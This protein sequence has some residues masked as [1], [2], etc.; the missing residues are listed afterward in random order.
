[1]SSSFRPNWGGFLAEDDNEY[2]QSD[3]P[4]PE[5]ELQEREIPEQEIPEQEIQ[6]QEDF[7]ERKGG[8]N[9]SDRNDL[10]RNDLDRNDLDRL[11]RFRNAQRNP[12]Q[13][14]KDQNTKNFHSASLIKKSSWRQDLEEHDQRY[15]KENQP[16]RS[17]RE[18][19]SRSNNDRSGRSRRKS[20]NEVDQD[21]L[22]KYLLSEL[23]IPQTRHR[24]SRNK[25]V[26]PVLPD[27]DDFDTDEN[28]KNMQ[29]KVQ[30]SLSRNLSKD[31]SRDL[32]KSN[33]VKSDLGK[34]DVDIYIPPLSKPA[35]EPTVN[36]SSKPDI[37]KPDASKPDFKEPNESQILDR[38]VRMFSQQL[39]KTRINTPIAESQAFQEDNRILEPQTPFSHFS[40]PQFFQAPQAPQPS[41][42]FSHFQQHQYQGSSSMEMPNAPIAPTQSVPSMQPIQPP[43]PQSS[44]HM[45]SSQPTQLAQSQLTQLNQLTQSQLTQLNQLTQSQ[46]QSQSVESMQSTLDSVS[47]ELKEIIDQVNWVKEALLNYTELQTRP[48]GR[49]SFLVPKGIYSRHEYVLNTVTD[50]GQKWG[51]RSRLFHTNEK[52]DLKN[53]PTSHHP[54]CLKRFQYARL[55]IDLSYFPI[56]LEG[57]RAYSC[58]QAPSGSETIIVHC[59][60]DYSSNKELKCAIVKPK[61]NTLISNHAFVQIGPISFSFQLF[62]NT[63]NI[64]SISNPLAEITYYI[65]MQVSHSRAIQSSIQQV[66][67]DD[68]RLYWTAFVQLTTSNI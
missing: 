24:V 21:R 59:W 46:S 55:E 31:L 53:P 32:S 64:L 40:Q 62:L 63:K 22:N 44:Q 54:I 30:S 61:V 10:D 12:N 42:P 18:G 2:Q 45:Q 14:Y 5:R 27:Q 7:E 65:D 4:L 37:L 66:F 15:K 23:P 48:S 41:Q 16:E 39:G 19:R 52:L 58:G 33:S 9:Y 13:E 56:P 60:P 51:K 68:Y 1:M 26:K 11:D 36:I 20:I 50:L 17:N 8:R 28:I 29:I 6:G 49:L 57:K 35:E 34:P 25:R 47:L 67:E 43:H 38:V 3:S